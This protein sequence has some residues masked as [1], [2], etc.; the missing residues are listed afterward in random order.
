M[1]ICTKCGA[2]AFDNAMLCPECG[3]FLSST[4]KPQPQAKQTQPTSGQT[5]VTAKP[6]PRAAQS[7][8]VNQAQSIEP[9]Q[10]IQNPTTVVQ[11]Q[12]PNY[13]QQ[14]PQYTQQ[15]PSNPQQ[16]PVFRKFCS[17]C[18]SEVLNN[19]SVC[20]KCGCLVGNTPVNTASTQYQQATGYSQ[21][22]QPQYTQ[23]APS[24]SQQQQPR[25]AQQAPSYSQ[26]QQPQYIP[27]APSNPQQQQYNQQFA[28][29]QQPSCQ[30]YGYE[31]KESSAPLI[32]NC[33][34]SILA[35]AS[36]LLWI[37]G[38]LEL[39]MDIRSYGIY[40]YFGDQ[41]IAGFVCALAAFAMGVVAL[42]VSLAQKSKK[43][44]VFSA[45]THI[46]IGA[47]LVL[48]ALISGIF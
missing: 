48:P 25:F 21:Q 34:S 3:G 32:F 31:K 35:A 44:Y 13:P 5:Q 2:E 19:A 10:N 6:I 7:T 36:V 4:K 43:D 1:K 8:D 12:T 37:L 14:Q 24:Y 20:L 40:F 47:A 29:I 27:Q 45:I 11:Q 16:T 9:A 39:D 30:A 42:I 33:I 28:N 26:Q 46:V 41:I 15:V 22:Q 23:Q 18:G 17:K 38:I